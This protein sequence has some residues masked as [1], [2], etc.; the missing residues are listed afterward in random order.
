MISAG[1]LSVDPLSGRRLGVVLDPSWI[2]W[3][4][5]PPGTTIT[6]GVGEPM[7]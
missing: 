6:S 1:A 2:G 7:A 3:V 4:P 5:K